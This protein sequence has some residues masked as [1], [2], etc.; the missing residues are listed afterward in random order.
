MNVYINDP[1]HDFEKENAFGLKSLDVPIYRI[2][3]KHYLVDAIQKSHLV[4]VKPASW[5]DPFENF[6]LKCKVTL[7]GHPVSINEFKERLYGLCWSL[8][9][10]TDAMW[11]IYSPYKVGEEDRKKDGIKVRTT[12]RKL[13]NALLKVPHKYAPLRY[14]IGAVEYLSEQKLVDFFSDPK[15]WKNF[16]LDSTA[17]G[18]VMALLLKRE[19][20]S[21]EKEVRVVFQC[22]KT[23][24]GDKLKYFPIDPNS[25]F[26]EI[27]FD[28]RILD[29]QIID[30]WTKELKGLGF[31]NPI[32]QSPM[33]KLPITTIKLD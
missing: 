31:Q 32:Y 2:M 10:E 16:T 30:D 8:H 19:E 33:Y 11:R 7:G 21:H 18:P 17:R 25:F 13:F 1:P 26:E 28:P 5:E 29:P 6:L 3:P 23:E 20:F 24:C 14:F 22:D 15:T 9:Q 4:L 27:V 12:A